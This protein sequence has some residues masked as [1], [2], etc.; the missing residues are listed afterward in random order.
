MRSTQQF[1]RTGHESTRVI[2]GAAALSEVTQDEADQTLELVRRHGINHLDTAASYGES[3]L[4]LAP[5]LAEHRDEVFLATKTGERTEEAAWAE[6]NRSLERLGVDHV[7]LLQLHNLVDEAEWQQAYAPDGVLAAAVRARD[8]GLVRAIG[9]TGHGVTV[10]RQHLRSLER[11]DFA[12][13]LLP[14]NYAMSQNR[15]YLDDFEELAA[16]CAERRVAMQTIKAITKAPWAEGAERHA[17]T[18]Y[19]PLTDPD[20]IATAVAWVLGRPGVHLN[21]VGD[22]HVLPTVLDAVER[23]EAEGGTRPDDEAMAGLERAWG[24]EPLFV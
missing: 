5:F 24:L 22:I 6:I 15:A 1:G 14:Y 21:T 17:A 9:V 19:E 23:F 16:V 10:A 3:E 13:V 8:E 20:A 2:F 12:S 18:W 7:D 4:R 11:F